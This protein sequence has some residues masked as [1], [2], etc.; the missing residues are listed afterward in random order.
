MNETK[1]MHKGFK[2][3]VLI[4]ILIVVIFIREDNQQKFINFFNKLVSRKTEIQLDR[5]LEGDNLTFFNGTLI[6]WE[7]NSISILNEDGSSRWTKEFDFI[8]PR[9]VYGSRNI[10][11]MDKLAGD[12]YIMDKMGDTVSSIQLYKEIFNLKESINGFIVHLKEEEKD[13]LEFIDKY[14]VVLKSLEGTGDV[15]T[16]SLNA[17]NSKYVYSNIDISNSSISSK[18]MVCS[19]EGKEEY[20]VN[21]PNEIVISTSFIKD[22]I[23]VTTDSSIKLIEK[24]VFKWS[25]EYPLIKDI[26]IDNNDIYLLYGDNLELLDL[27]GESKGKITF[28][29]EYNKIIPVESY[30]A[31]Y[32]NKDLLILQDFQEV[33]KYKADEDI[34]NVTGNV[35]SIALHYKNKLEIYKI[36]LSKT[37]K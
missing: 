28:G 17:D 14:G 21:I 25:K 7:Q 8:E 3:F 30:I 37:T 36:I 24:G 35:N 34:L 2:I 18:L 29:V 10:Y 32:S 13:S 15:L 23:V 4:L 6:K 5:S 19:I 26:F 20:S 9:V 22:K 1:V 33:L 16:Y 27:N 11:I 31:L 12:I